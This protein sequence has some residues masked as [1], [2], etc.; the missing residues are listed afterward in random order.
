MTVRKRTFDSEWTFRATFVR[1][2]DGDTVFVS[3]DQGLRHFTGSAD[4]P[5]PVRIDGINTAEMNDKDKKAKALADKALAFVLERLKPGDR[6]WI[7]TKKQEGDQLR[8]KYGR[9]L[10]SVYYLPPKPP[11]PKLK[12]GQKAPPPA[13]DEWVCLNDELRDAGLAV[14]YHGGTRGAFPTD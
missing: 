4:S 3:L 1:A 10:A 6:L 11:A 8:D 14:E 5:E 7:A 12:K 2:H 13:P 9:L